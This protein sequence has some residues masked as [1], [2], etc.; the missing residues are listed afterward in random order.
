MYIRRKVFSTIID[1]NGEE[2]YFSSS[3]IID[4]DTYLDELMYSEDEDL[5]GEHT[6]SMES[7][8]LGVVF[9]GA[10]QAK[11]A[12]KYGYDKDE[13]RNKRAKYAVLGAL[14]PGTATVIKKKAEAMAK[15]GK[16]K[17]EI[18]NYLENPKTERYIV[19]TGEAV[20]PVARGIGSL[21]ARGIGI[22]DK[23]QGHRAW[24]E[25]KELEKI[26]KKKQHKKHKK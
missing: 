4:E 25:E 19:G 23:L 14:T 24:D 21:A 1:E 18:R 22:A 15:E 5:L 10:Y 20:I 2:K 12:A 3:E 13:Y 16:S 9:P 11:E 8:A 26:R 17:K 7:K 6:Y